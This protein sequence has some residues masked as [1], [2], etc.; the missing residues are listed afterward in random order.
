VIIFPFLVIDMF[1]SSCRPKTYE[2]YLQL[3]YLDSLRLFL[4]SILVL[5]LSS[6][7]C[8]KLPTRRNISRTWPVT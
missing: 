5:L 7:C 4:T 6:C 3:V 8:M 1:V 2:L